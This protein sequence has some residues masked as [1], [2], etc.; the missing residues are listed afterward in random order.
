MQLYYDVIYQNSYF[1][2]QKNKI[3]KKRQHISC[4]KQIK[5]FFWYEMRWMQFCREE[6]E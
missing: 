3:E 1:L 6:E 4:V 5:T 2:K